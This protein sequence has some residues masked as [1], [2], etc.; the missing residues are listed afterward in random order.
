LQYAAE[1]EGHADNVASS[2][3]GGFTVS[4]TGPEGNVI[5]IRRAWPAAIKIVVVSP[6]TP[7][8][9]RL[10]RAALPRH[11]NHVD[12]VYNLQRVA[13]FSA[14]LFERR[15]ELLWEAMQDRLK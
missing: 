14:A 11:V 7:V 3:L 13:L 9:T 15:Y 5:A 4:C 2:L 12:A 10:A 8:E 1:F 6:E